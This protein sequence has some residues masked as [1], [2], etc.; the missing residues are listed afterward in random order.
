M[1]FITADAS[2]PKRVELKI[3]RATFDQIT[4]GVVERCVGCVKQ[5]LCEAKI[6]E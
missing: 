1:P 2:G 5:A 3:T 6:S 4:A